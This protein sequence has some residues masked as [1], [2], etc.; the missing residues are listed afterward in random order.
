MAPQ[1][2]RRILLP[3]DFSPNPSIADP[4]AVALARSEGAEILLATVVDVRRDHVGPGPDAPHLGPS[5]GSPAFEL[6][7]DEILGE[8][9]R[10]LAE[11]PVRGGE[12]VVIRREVVAHEHAAAGLVELAERENVDVIVLSSHGRGV[13][14]QFFL[15][16]VARDVIE[17]AKCPVLCVKRGEAGLVDASTGRL[18]VA[19]VAV[20]GDDSVESAQ[21]FEFASG[22]AALYGARLHF[23][24][25][26]VRDIPAVVFAPDGE[27]ILPIDE[28]SLRLVRERRAAF[29]KVV[30]SRQADV[31][32]ELPAGSEEKVLSVYAAEQGIDVV[33]L[34]RRGLG[35]AISF[36][37]GAPT[38]LLHEIRCPLLLV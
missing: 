3:T 16:S 31:K 21:A 9:R 34:S 20:A 17:R 25:C 10:A 7:R 37:G 28:T 19:N 14:G 24:F 15:G 5:R 11:W 26:P 33:V 8:A 2:P 23:L 30:E 18:V 6:H 13:L 35:D 27:P 22:V 29:E 38:R 36:S 1:R 4:Y 32:I 12:N